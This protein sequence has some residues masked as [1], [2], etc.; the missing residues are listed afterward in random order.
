MVEPIVDRHTA[1]EYLATHVTPTLTKG[2]TAL[3]KAKPADPVTW[4]ADWL[5]ENNPNKPKVT[6]A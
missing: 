6:V 1:R 5:L 2:L 3:S 4:L